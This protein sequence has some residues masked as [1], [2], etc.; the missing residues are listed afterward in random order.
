MESSHS[1]T[2][3]VPFFDGEPINYAIKR[4]DVGGKL[5]TNY[6]KDLIAIR[7]LNIKSE[8]RLANQIKEEISY[9]S[10]NFKDEIKHIKSIPP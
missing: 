6:L 5:I 4:V 7:Y 2:Y 8:L 3:I 9:L 1:A 10:L